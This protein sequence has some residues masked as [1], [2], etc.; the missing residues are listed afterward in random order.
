MTIGQDAL[1]SLV[2]KVNAALALASWPYV[3]YEG[4]TKHPHISDQCEKLA[5]RRSQ[6]LGEVA[7]DIAERISPFLPRT[8]SRIIVEAAEDDASPRL[9]D[10]AIG[11]IKTCLESHERSVFTAVGIPGLTTRM[12]RTDTIRY[13]FIFAT[14]LESLAALIAWFVDPTMPAWSAKALIGVPIFTIL[15]GLV[16]AGVL[17]TFTHTARWITSPSGKE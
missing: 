4:F 16:C 17:R 9:S 11:E 14:A 13:W 8:T 1:V 2:P 5:L 12:L 3:L 7:F 15:V 10:D 6:I